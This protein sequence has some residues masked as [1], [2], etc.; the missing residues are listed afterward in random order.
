MR[1]GAAGGGTDG[2]VVGALT[3]L[4]AFFVASPAALAPL[5]AASPALLAASPM[6]LAASEAE[7][8]A[9]AFLA[10]GVAGV[11][12]VLPLSSQPIIVPTP[13]NAAAATII[14]VLRIMNPT[15]SVRDAF[16]MPLRRRWRQQLLQKQL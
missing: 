7:A 8:L 11:E 12:V 4:A 1:Y 16:M 13:T 10:A 15:P 3:E 2:A 5:L 9:S 14:A 6:L